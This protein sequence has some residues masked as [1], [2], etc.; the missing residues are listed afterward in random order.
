[1][2]RDTV[3]ERPV[4]VKLLAEH[5]PMMRRSSTASVA[6][7]SPPRAPPAPE[8]RA[9][10]DSG[11]D[12]NTERHYIVMEYV[13]GPSAADMLRERKQLEVGETVRSCATPATG[14]TT[15]TGPGSST[16]T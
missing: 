10:F 7:R 6:R 2:A 5:L 13:D 8:H 9:V 3:L 12:P 16:A 1:M 14:S 4:A 11:Q 15:R